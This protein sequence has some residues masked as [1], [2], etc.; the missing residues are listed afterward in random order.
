[1]QTQEITKILN[2]KFKKLKSMYSFSYISTST[3][4]IMNIE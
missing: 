4:I 1:M 3:M 2:T